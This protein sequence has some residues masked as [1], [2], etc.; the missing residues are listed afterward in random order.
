MYVYGDKYN[1]FPFNSKKGYIYGIQNS[2][3]IEESTYFETYRY[4]HFSDHIKY[5]QSHATVNILAR[6][7]NVSYTV[8]KKYYNESFQA[9]IDSDELN[10]TQNFN[11]NIYAQSNFPYIED[12]SNLL[13][14]LNVNNARYNADDDF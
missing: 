11:K 9:I 14:Q 1:N 5:T 12:R 6:S 4:G 2:S 13:S 10:L 3:R 7:L 8:E